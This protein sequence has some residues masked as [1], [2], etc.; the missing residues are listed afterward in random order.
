[1]SALW[2][3]LKPP[4]VHLI[5]PPAYTG[6]YTTRLIRHWIAQA[7]ISEVELGDADAI[8]VSICDPRDLPVLMQARAR[9]QGRP[10]IMGGFEGYCGNPYLAW[11]N[12]VVVGE[13]WEFI[14]AWGRDVDEA[15][16]LP[17]VLTHAGQSV[18]P[19]YVLPWTECPVI[20]FSGGRR[21][22]LLA[23]RGCANKCSFCLTS[24]AQPHKVAP[25][26]Y[27]AAGRR[28][29][30]A[31][32]MVLTLIGND[33]P[34]PGGG[35]LASISVRLRDWLSR[36]SDYR[37]SMLHVGVEGWTERDRSLL[38]KP[39]SD[40]DLHSFIVET[41][42]HKQQ[43]ELFTIAGYP[44]WTAEAMEGA[45]DTF[46]SD[47]M[48][49]PELRLKVTYFDP[50]P[51][52][53]LADTPISGCHVDV[54]ALCARLGSHSRRWRTYPMASSART[55]WRSCFHRCLPDE[56][57][58]LGREPSDTNT[59]GSFERF[60]AERL[61]PAGLE[62]LLTRTKACNNIETDTRR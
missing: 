35:H 33:A 62:G 58:M 7:G 43:V 59:E 38:G 23:G 41:G 3:S 19:S 44:G 2:K 47:A 52:T 8:W 37:A 4:S 13:G 9:A 30:R 51:H 14:Q 20:R 1:M 27:I 36:P 31:S 32:K 28:A 45:I 48:L 5:S 22:Y 50:C 12:A 18:A 25:S 34:D 11:A 24:W 61:R 15:M 49:R 21:A 46:P 57:K 53:P 29:A 39:I 40:R 55:A 17:C 56:A 42:E 26:T 6:L 54:R 16:T 10:V 60:V